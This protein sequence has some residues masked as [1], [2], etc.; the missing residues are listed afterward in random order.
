MAK[1][2]PGDRVVAITSGFVMV[3]VE[4][5]RLAEGELY[6][7]SHPA[8][9][10]NPDLFA[11]DSTPHGERRKQLQ[12]L[13]NPP[14]EP[15]P[16]ADYRPR[17]PRLRDEDASLCI[18]SAGAVHVAG[19]VGIVVGEPVGARPGD[20]IP[21]KSKLVKD[22]PTAFVKVVPPGLKREDALVALVDM[23]AEPSFR[24][25]T[26]PVRRVYAGQWVPRDS[27][28]VASHPYAFAWVDR[29]R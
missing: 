15:K 16:Q 13:Y 28:F 19:E 29:D 26:D 25:P 1:F 27:P 12:V 7:G 23:A 4:E 14:E 8:V 20:R 11:L 6:V 24:N 9:Q 18:R 5:Y 17:P 2:A 21:T 3:G 22:N 10:S